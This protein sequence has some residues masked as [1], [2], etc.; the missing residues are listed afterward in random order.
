MYLNQ[1]LNNMTDKQLEQIVSEFD[2]QNSCGVYL[3]NTESD[4]EDNITEE[5]KT[6]NEVK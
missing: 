3:P 5:I 4:S 2:E 6:N 1:K